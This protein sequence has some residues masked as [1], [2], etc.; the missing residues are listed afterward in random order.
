MTA[1]S[2]RPTHRPILTRGYHLTRLQERLIASAYEALFPVTVC[3]TTAS[4]SCHGDRGIASTEK[5]VART[6][7]RGA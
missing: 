1:Q 6:Q 2:G 3:T 7:A 5:A 4:Q